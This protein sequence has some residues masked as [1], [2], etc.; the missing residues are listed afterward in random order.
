MQCNV[1]MPKLVFRYLQSVPL[2]AEVPS[3]PLYF[4][5]ACIHLQHGYPSD[6][7]SL[8]STPLHSFTL[9][10]PVWRLPPSSYCLDSFI[11]ILI[12]FACI[13]AATFLVRSKHFSNPLNR[14]SMLTDSQTEHRQMQFHKY[15][16]YSTALI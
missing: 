9:Y 12:R 4:V 10:T 15:S 8:L 7:R 13:K 16:H 6:P 2:P 14:R 1:L 3:L 5:F 11:N